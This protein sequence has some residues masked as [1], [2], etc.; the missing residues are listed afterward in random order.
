MANLSQGGNKS[1]RIKTLDSKYERG[2]EVA[3][4]ILSQERIENS[5]MLKKHKF[6]RVANG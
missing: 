1:V 4:Q 5:Q 2:N 3:L 6:V